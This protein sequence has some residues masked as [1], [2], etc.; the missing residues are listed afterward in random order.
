MPHDLSVL[1]CDF[2]SAGESFLDS[3]K[4][5]LA[6][7]CAR[8]GSLARV[9]SVSAPVVS[10]QKTTLCFKW[11]NCLRYNKPDV[12]LRLTFRLLDEFPFDPCQQLCFVSSRGVFVVGIFFLPLHPARQTVLAEIIKISFAL[13]FCQTFYRSHP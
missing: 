3:N 8:V 6:D 11:N 4:S 12:F 7:R 2:L 5:V 1:K 13:T 9:S 10:L